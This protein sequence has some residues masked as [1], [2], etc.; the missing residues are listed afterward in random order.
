LVK[1]GEDVGLCRSEALIE[2][3]EELDAVL[4]GD[5]AA[6]SP[7]SRIRVAFDQGRRFEV[8]EEVGHD[9]PVDAKVLGQGELAP[10]SALG[11]SGKDLVAPRTAWEVGDRLMGGGHVGPKD[12][13][14]S[15]SEVVGQGVVAATG[16]PD[17]DSVTRGVVHTLII[18]PRV[19]SVVP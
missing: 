2:L 17:L 9:G 1:G 6:S 5:N 15:P 19:R 12:R 16:N 8:I 4:G 10:N 13:A 7:I 14:E 3:G 18:R 11:G